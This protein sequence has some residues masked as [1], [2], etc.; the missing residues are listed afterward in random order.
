[1]W[2]HRFVMSGHLIKNLIALLVPVHP[3]NMGSLTISNM[4]ELGFSLNARI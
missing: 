4:M 1:M 2:D 3:L